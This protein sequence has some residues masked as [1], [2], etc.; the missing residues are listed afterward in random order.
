MS[1]APKPDHQHIVLVMAKL[2]YDF[3][4]PRRLGR[5]FVSPIDVVVSARRA[6]QPDI[7][8]ISRANLGIIRDQIRGAPDLVVEVISEGT[9]RRDRIDKKALYEQYGIKEYWLIDPEAESIEVYELMA[10]AYKLHAKTGGEQEA[11]SKLLPSFKVA[12]SQLTG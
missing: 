10:G 5:V 9:W 6:V 1:P 11:S 8:F 3:A 12:F 2:L 4:T 7:V